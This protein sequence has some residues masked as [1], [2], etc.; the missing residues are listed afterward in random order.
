[1]TELVQIEDMKRPRISGS[2]H[3]F[4]PR[5]QLLSLYYPIP[6]LYSL[7]VTFKP[8]SPARLMLAALAGHM[9]RALAVRRVC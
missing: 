5:H 7:V 4:V 2:S 8:A 1:M 6:S 3:Y 9:Q